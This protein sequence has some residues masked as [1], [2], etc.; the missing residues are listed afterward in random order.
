MDLQA[1]RLLYTLL[2]RLASKVRQGEQNNR[3]AKWAGKKKEKARTTSP[4]DL[5][6]SVAMQLYPGV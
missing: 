1:Q 2:L 3:C 6:H 4:P 5:A